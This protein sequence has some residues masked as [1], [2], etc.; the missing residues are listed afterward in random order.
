PPGAIVALD[1]PPTL[2]SY[3]VRFGDSLSSIALAHHV[4]VDGL[5]AANNLASESR[6]VPGLLLTI[7]EAAPADVVTSHEVQTGET[8]AEIALDYGVTQHALIVANGLRHP[9]DIS[10]GMTL[11][12]PGVTAGFGT[13]MVGDGPGQ[14]EDVTVERS[15]TGYFSRPTRA[16]IVSQGYHPWHPAIDLSA[17]TGTPILAADGGTVTYAGWSPVGYGNLVILDHGNGWLTYYAH[18]ESVVVGCAQWVRRGGLLGTMGSTGNSTGPHL[19][20]E[21][22][23]FGEAIDPNG[24]IRF[25]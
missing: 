17:D 11:T 12:I 16:A 7:P 25:D 6:L 23:R 1:A 10:T 22:I 9:G 13:I 14:C 20:F 24:Y 2:R 15:G 3:R 4:T 19:H 5:I 18:L 8:L 21:M